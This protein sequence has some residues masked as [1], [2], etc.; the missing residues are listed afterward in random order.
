MDYHYALKFFFSEFLGTFVLIFLGNGAV[1]CYDLKATKG[2]QRPVGGL[3]WL[4]VGI[5]YGLAVFI[6][7]IGSGFSNHQLNPAAT[8]LDIILQIGGKGNT[9]EHGYWLVPVAL[10]AQ[11]VG[12]MASQLVLDGLF[13]ISF[14]ET[15]DS[16]KIFAMHATTRIKSDK[17]SVKGQ[18]L[19][20]FCVETVCTFILLIGL[21]GADLYFA[22]GKGTFDLTESSKNFIFGITA[23]LLVMTLVIGAGGITGPALN[24][25]RDLAPRIIYTILPLPNK[26]M[27]SAEWNYAWV[28]IVGPLLGATLAAG[29]FLGLQSI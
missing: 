6:G 28:P 23:G 5:G 9:F 17:V 21:K 20:A 7:V 22:A 19:I 25:T 27:K 2:T 26:S 1:A 16:S 24:P 12:A 15:D 10:L 18:F 29:V 11:F 14:K 8:L 3:S 4:G 13:Y